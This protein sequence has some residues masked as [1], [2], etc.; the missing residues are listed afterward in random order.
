ML[1]T[2]ISGWIPKRVNKLSYVRGCNQNKFICEIYY[3]RP[4]DCKIYPATIEDMVKDG[5]EMLEKQDLTYPKQAQ[6]T[7]DILMSD[8]RPPYV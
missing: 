2:G 6:K 1:A 3:D 5:C 4:D 8:S 7:L